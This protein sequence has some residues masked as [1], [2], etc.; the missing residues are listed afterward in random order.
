M[1]HWRI[2][3]FVKEV[4]EV[5]DAGMKILLFSTDEYFVQVFG[6]FFTQK[7]TAADLFCYTEESAAREWLG[8]EQA[9]LIFCEEGYLSE[10]ANRNGFILLG[11]QTVMPKDGEVGSLNIYQ[12]SSAI[13]ED[14]QRLISVCCGTKDIVNRKEKIVAVYSAEGGSGKTTISYL[15]AV[16]S[17]KSRKTA[18]LNLEPLFLP[19]GFYEQQFRHSMEQLLFAMKGGTKLQELLYETLQQNEDGVYVLPEIKSFGDYKEI[20]TDIIDKLCEAVSAAG[21]EWIFLDL[22]GGVSSFTEKILEMSCHILW[23]F[24]GTEKGRNKEEAV[25]NDPYLKKFM[26]KSS[27]IRNRCERKED[28][29]GATVGFPYSGTIKKA[30]AV[31]NVL[32]VNKEFADGCRLLESNILNS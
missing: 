16:Q 6:N 15:T 22:P 1:Y 14:V 11:R 17:A 28:A 29:A 19:Y 30:A 10:Y 27:F 8:K 3:G 5:E 21:I 18:Y 12:R 23:C 32:K 2:S 4:R 25:K 9:E 31:S 24:S 13:L 7:N 26:G 20:N